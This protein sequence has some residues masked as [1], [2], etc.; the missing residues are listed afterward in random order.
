MSAF[1]LPNPSIIGKIYSSNPSS[2]S[3]L[4]QLLCH[5]S[6]FPHF[7]WCHSFPLSDVPSSK[8]HSSFKVQLN[9]QLLCEASYCH[10]SHSDLYLSQVQFDMIFMHHNMS[11]ILPFVEL[12]FL[13]IHS[14]RSGIMSNYFSD[15]HMA[16]HMGWFHKWTWLTLLLRQIPSISGVSSF[17]LNIWRS[18]NF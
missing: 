7:S 18:T 17:C 2:H 1:Q 3:I 13:T 14:L 6:L 8:S 5:R 12:A 16:S 11:S 15:L 9:F 4:I 10:S